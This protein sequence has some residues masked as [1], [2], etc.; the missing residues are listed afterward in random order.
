MFGDRVVIFSNSAGSNDDLG[1]PK[2]RIIEESL[3]VAVLR[4]NTKVGPW[5]DLCSLES[6]AAPLG[7]EASTCPF[8]RFLPTAVH[9]NPEALSTSS[10]SSV[11]TW[12][13]RP[14]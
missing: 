5:L 6:S 3:G 4:H 13:L 8:T 11:R 9:R 14:L 7:L 12:T 2:A 1:F 10:N